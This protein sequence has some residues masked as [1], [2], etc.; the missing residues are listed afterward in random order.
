MGMDI[1]ELII[2]TI[3]LLASCMFMGWDCNR[4]YLG[5]LRT[6]TSTIIPAICWC[7]VLIELN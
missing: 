6:D 7:M 3:G 1:W 4:P 2:I 5:K